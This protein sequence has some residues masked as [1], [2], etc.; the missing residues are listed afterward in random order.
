MNSTQLF[1]Q[2]D[3]IKQQMADLRS[4]LKLIEEQLQDLYMGFARDS[5]RSDGRDFGTTHIVADGH[6]LKATVTKKVKWDQDKL[7]QALDSMTADEARHYAKAT[8]AVEERKYNAAPPAI[9]EVLE[10]CR[11][12]EIGGFTVEVERED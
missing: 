9:R 3:E 7:R 5:L 4:E 11:T 6:K 1:N 8:F 12:T 10:E 2:R